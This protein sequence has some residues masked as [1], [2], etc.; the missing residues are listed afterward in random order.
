MTKLS[1]V[2]VVGFIMMTCLYAFAQEEGLQKMTDVI[3]IWQGIIKIQTIELRIVFNISQ[4]P[5]GKL[6]AKMDSPDQGAKDIPID[7]VTFENGNLSL[8]L[9][10]VGGDFE[11]KY[12]DDG[13]IKGN[14]SQSGQSL[15][16]ILSKTDK[17]PEAQRPQDPKK[18]YPYKEEE[19]IY[20]NKR[21]GIKLAG[22]LT[23]PD[24][25]ESFPVVL[26]ISGSGPQ[27]RDETVFGHRPFLVLADYL[28]RQGIAV[29]RTDDRGVGGSTGDFSQ[30]TTM[31]F[32]D[33]ALAG[34]EYLKSRKEINPKQIGLIG[35]SEGGVIA[36]IVATESADVAFIVLMAGTG[37]T[38]EEVLYSQGRLM[39]KA[40]GISDETIA[41]GLETNKR[42]FAVLKEEDSAVAEKKIRE[43]INDA[44]AGMTDQEK[45]TM[46]NIEDQ[47][48]SVLSPWLRFFLTYDPKPTLMKVKCPVLA[49]N[50]SKDLQVSSKENLSAIED[51][52]KSGDNKNYT[53]KELPNLN[54]LF[55]TSQTGSLTEYAKIEET[56][57]PTALRVIGDWILEQTKEKH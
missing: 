6:T 20:E 26:L 29:L 52:L 57:S 56:I 2:L 4:S 22:T 24:S 30:A 10:S 47:I 37:L 7:E 51:A 35:H 54:H 55:Q 1:F 17:A 45:Q 53:V 41:K 12:Q 32:A 18:P 40:E 28:T 48:K 5:D 3:G 43:I 39:A 33:D 44:I 50:G 34:V 21:A 15:P 11:G 42:I 8:K 31:D 25:G 46:P 27:D 14:W 38:G 13:T 36:P 23:L 49:I 9:K 19:V 16:I